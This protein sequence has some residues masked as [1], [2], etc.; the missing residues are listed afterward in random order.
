MPVFHCRT[1]LANPFSLQSGH[2][3]A[4]GGSDEEV[5]VQDFVKALLF[6]AF[7]HFTLFNFLVDGCAVAAA[8][9]CYFVVL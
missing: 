8:V 6:C 1:A 7:S 5:E 9:G 4:T 3:P 2:Q